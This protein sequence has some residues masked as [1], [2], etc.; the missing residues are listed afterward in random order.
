MLDRFAPAGKVEAIVPKDDRL[1]LSFVGQAAQD[2]AVALTA[3]A[4]GPKFGE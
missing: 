2:D 4:H 3:A 1:F